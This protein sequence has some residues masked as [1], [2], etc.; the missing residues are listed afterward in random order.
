MK[1]LLVLE[2]DSSRRIL[3]RH[4]K[5]FR[6][7]E[8]TTAEEALRLFIEHGRQLDLLIADVKLPRSTGIQVALLL[9]T[10]ILNLPVLLT[11]GNSPGSWDERD[12][13]DLGRLGS[14]SVSI[15]G[16]PFHP[17]VVLNAVRTL[18]EGAPSAMVRTA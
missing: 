16:K 9:R 15:L 10:E 7:I 4:M 5:Q 1:A 8:A 18:L 17:Q 14:D 11:S 12:F 3:R 2:D 6:L 13:A